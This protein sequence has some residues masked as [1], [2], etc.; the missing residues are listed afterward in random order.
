LRKKQLVKVALIFPG[1]G[2]QAVGMGKEFYNSSPE[3]KAIFD[4]ADQL[5]N[6]LSDVIFYGPQEKLTSTAF[7]QPAIFTYSFAALEAF[8]V[9]PKFQTIEPRFAAGFSLGECTAVA[10]AGVLSFEE[11]LKLVERRSFYM[12]EA[13]KAEHGTMAAIIGFDQDKLAAICRDTGAEV[14]NFN[15]P[16]QIVITGR[17]ESVGNAC[18]MIKEQ[19]AKRVVPLNVSGAF[20][21]SLMQSAVPKFEEELGKFK[22]KEAG[23]PVVSNVDGQPT[24]DPEGIRGNLAKQIISSVQW[25]NSVQYIAGQGVNDLLEIGPGNVLKG[26]IRSINPELTV[27]N[28]RIPKDL[29]NLPY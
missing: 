8:R 28:I 6:G 14:A 21:S 22:F 7:C 11:T 20:H 19:G 29:D 26:L 5:I 27:H 18:D 23:F 25:V 10:A 17:A 1:Q 9:H 12:D 15:S 4:K 16:D 13:T 2:A 3:A 24:G